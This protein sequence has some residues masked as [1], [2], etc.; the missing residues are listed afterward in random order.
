MATFYQQI[1]GSPQELGDLSTWYQDEACTIPATSLPTASDDV[2]VG[3]AVANSSNFE[4]ANMDVYSVLSCNSG[5][6]VVVHGQTTF[7]NGSSLGGGG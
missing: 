2:V 6:D 1:S 7:H 4:C 3:Y 5:Y